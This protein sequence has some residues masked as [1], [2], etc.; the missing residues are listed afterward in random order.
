MDA[1]LDGEESS[2]AQ[3]SGTHPTAVSH[4]NRAWVH[5][6][7][8]NFKWVATPLCLPCL[9]FFNGRGN[10]LHL[11]CNS[12]W[13]NWALESYFLDSEY[14]EHSNEPSF[15]KFYY[16]FDWKVSEMFYSHK[17]HVIQAFKRFNM[18]SYGDKIFLRFTKKLMSKK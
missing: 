5:C 13:R 14:Y 6:V 18:G 16:L 1:S 8:H 17:T 15:I 11:D 9:H 10:M 4:R 3:S 7:W 2:G 12:H